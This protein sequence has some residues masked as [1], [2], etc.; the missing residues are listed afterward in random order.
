MSTKKQTNTVQ[1]NT[2]DPTSMNAFKTATGQVGTF[3]K[4]WLGAS[5]DATPG[6]N[7]NYQSNL[8]QANAING[9]NVRNVTSNAL[10]LGGNPNSAAT[11]AILAR[12]ARGASANQFGAYANAYSNA[13]QQQNVAAS[14]AAAYRP[15]QTG[16][17]QNTTE[18]T[19]GTGTWLPQVIGAGLGMAT[20][21]MNPLSKAGAAGGGMGSAAG[22][23][24]GSFFS[25]GLNPALQASMYNQGFNV[26]NPNA[27]S[28]WNQ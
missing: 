4:N 27:T 16:G 18:T 8:A 10:T 9:R 20:G 11:Q 26:G 21:F 7:M 13:L 19:S 3:T 25:G 1:T 28:F 15:L 24:G 22:G 14:M 23:G 17:T 5:P 2:Y 6:F 12:T